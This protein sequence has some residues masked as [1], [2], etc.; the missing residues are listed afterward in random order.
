[1]SENSVKVSWTIYYELDGAAGGEE[2]HVQISYC[3]SLLNTKPLHYPIAE[4]SG[5]QL[6]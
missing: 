1:M 6:F 2:T 4:M 3:T 5:L